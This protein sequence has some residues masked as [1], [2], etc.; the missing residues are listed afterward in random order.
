[1]LYHTTKNFTIP[2]P[3]LIKTGVYGRIPGDLQ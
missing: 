2:H 3:N 1:L